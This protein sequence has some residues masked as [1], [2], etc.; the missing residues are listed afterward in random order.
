MDS[1]PEHLIHFFKELTTTTAANGSDAE[2]QRERHDENGKKEKK[3]KNDN[4]KKLVCTLNGHVLVNDEEQV[5]NFTRSGIG[6]C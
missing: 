5:K 4:E 1:I 6:S 2:K 3:K